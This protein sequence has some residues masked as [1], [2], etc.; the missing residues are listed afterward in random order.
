MLVDPTIDIALFSIAVVAFG[1]IVQEKIGS[2]KILKEHQE[3]VK[4]HQKRIQEI[5]KNKDV[6]SLSE[7][8][9]NEVQDLQTQM[10]KGTQEMM[11]STMK[12]MM[13]TMPVFLGVFWVLQEFYSGAIVQLAV[14]VPFFSLVEPFPWIT[15][16]QL[17]SSTNWFGW[18]ILVSL[19]VSLGI[20]VILKG[21]EK[22]KG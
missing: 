15:G 8:E 17:Y 16:I 19:I 12:Q 7:K 21:I 2:R 11:G 5:T 1:R 18:Y 4:E 20:N 10:I 6:S 14:P 22:I 13:Y 3:K 9:K